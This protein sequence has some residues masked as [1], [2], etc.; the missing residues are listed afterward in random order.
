MCKRLLTDTLIYFVSSRT[1]VLGTVQSFVN[2]TLIPLRQRLQAF[3][4]SGYSA[5]YLCPT[6]YS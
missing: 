5:V 4:A 1:K 6:T 3:L 2:A